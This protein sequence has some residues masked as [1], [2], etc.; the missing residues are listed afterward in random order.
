MERLNEGNMLHNFLMAQKNMPVKNDWILQLYKDKVELNI[1][2]KD[3]ILLKMS[4]NK[5]K[6]YVKKKV[7][8]LNT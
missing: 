8:L 2:E 5:F 1:D 6:N 4:K 7:Q 3:E